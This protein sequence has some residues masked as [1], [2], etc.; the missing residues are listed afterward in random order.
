MGMGTLCESADENEGA[1]YRRASG[2]RYRERFIE[3]WHRVKGGYTRRG[4]HEE[5]NHAGR[6]VGG[7]REGSPR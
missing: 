2:E 1:R 4:E 3:L 6:H 5:F 7:T